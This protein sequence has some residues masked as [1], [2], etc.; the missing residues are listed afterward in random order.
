MRIAAIVLSIIGL[1]WVGTK[2]G[3]LNKVNLNKKK[4]RHYKSDSED[5]FSLSNDQVYSIYQDIDCFG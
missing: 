1:I 5:P 2:G 3:G 4:F